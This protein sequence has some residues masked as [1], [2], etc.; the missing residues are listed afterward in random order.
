MILKQLIKYENANALEA[1]WVDAD[2]IQVKC[3]AYS[4]S[5]MDLLEADLGGDVVNYTS[6]IAEVR[7]AYVPPIPIPETISPVTPR[8]IRMALTR[9]G[10]RES[11]ETAVA[12]GTQDLKDWYEFSTMFYRDQPLVIQMGESLGQTPEQL[13]GLWKLAATL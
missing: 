8:Q 7:A 1:T 5:Q 2:G 10:L 4:D 11:V 13:D 12:A 9:T 3:Q 6:L